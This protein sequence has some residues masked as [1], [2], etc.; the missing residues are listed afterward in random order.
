MTR[1]LS[2]IALALTLTLGSACAGRSVQSPGDAGTSSARAITSEILD[3]SLFD[4]GYPTGA[5]AVPA[6]E[7]STHP[8][9]A[10]SALRTAD[11][12]R[13]SAGSWDTYF[14]P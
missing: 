3:L 5:G 8:G 10:G 7:A 4:P 13:S 12:G 9:G 6:N 2:V 1:S 14:T 11:T